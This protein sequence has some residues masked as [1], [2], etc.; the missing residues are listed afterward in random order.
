MGFKWQ[1][2]A[3]MPGEI[4]SDPRVATSA[5]GRVLLHLCVASYVNPSLFVRDRKRKRRY[6]VIKGLCDSI[7][8]STS[9][10]T[11][12]FSLTKSIFVYA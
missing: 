4:E 8:L 9:T 10:S 3:W 12:N 11:R 2:Q 6:R 5:A 7:I 1:Y